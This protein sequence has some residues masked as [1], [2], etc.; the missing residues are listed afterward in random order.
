MKA[1][2]MDRLYRV[3][4]ALDFD[5]VAIRALSE[6]RVAVERLQEL[7]S[8]RQA[9]QQAEP[10]GAAFV[11]ETL[12]RLPTFTA[13]SARP[14][15]WIGVAAGVGSGALATLATLFAL[16]AT[17]AAGLASPLPLL[18]V[19]LSV[20]IV[21]GYRAVRPPDPGEPASAL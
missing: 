9:V 3:A 18:F 11:E 12:S 6:N 10:V 16:L 4:E 14:A 17:G 20:G 13:A 2:D 7:L 1:L 19:A 8:V 5:P 15:N 21:A